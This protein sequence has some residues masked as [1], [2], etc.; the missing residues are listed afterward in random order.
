MALNGIMVRNMSG[1]AGQAGLI[2]LLIMVVVTTVAVSVSTRSVSELRISRQEQESTRTLNLAESGIE[3]LLRDNLDTLLAGGSSTT[4]TRPI[5]SS[6]ITYSVEKKDNLDNYPLAVG[7]SVDIDLV[8][9]DSL[10]IAW[11][12]GCS[13]VVTLI[14]DSGLDRKVWKKDGICP[15]IGSTYTT[16]IVTTGYKKAVIKAIGVA[17]VVNL[18]R[19]CSGTCA[20][21][22][23]EVS[24]TA[25]LADGSNRKV[26]VYKTPGSLPSIFDYVLFSGTSLEK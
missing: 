15:G 13:L 3:D 21:S 2:V 22:V 11:N 23:Y 5:A 17:A 8:D 4:G 10:A 24:S 12:S 25:T 26:T 16:P 9:V 1:Q 14:N 20:G 19:T 18:T 7:H 6:I